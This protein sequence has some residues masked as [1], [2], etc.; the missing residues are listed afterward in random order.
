MTKVRIEKDFGNRITLTGYSPFLKPG[1][2]MEVDAV[3]TDGTDMPT[4]WFKGKA[5]VEYQSDKAFMTDEG[6]MSFPYVKAA[7]WNR[8]DRVIAS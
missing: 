4:S 3:I 7:H 8:D 6:F 2:I 5:V 1:M